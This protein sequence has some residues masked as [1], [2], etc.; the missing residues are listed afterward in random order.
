MITADE[1]R[2]L[3]TYESRVQGLLAVIET[4]IRA[5]APSILNPRLTFGVPADDKSRPV[6]DEVCRVLRDD[7]KFTVTV[8]DYYVENGLGREVRK[9]EIIVE[10][11]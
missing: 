2:A 5:R 6:V 10:W 11:A 7:G 1:A 8:S 4:T 3:G 9:Q